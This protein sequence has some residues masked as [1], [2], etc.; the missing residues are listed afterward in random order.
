MTKPRD[1]TRTDMTQVF[2]AIEASDFDAAVDLLVMK[3]ERMSDKAEH[4]APMHGALWAIRWIADVEGVKSLSALR[5]LLENH[6][7]TE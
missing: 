2:E 1:P 5:K 6:G 3:I 4:K 7:F